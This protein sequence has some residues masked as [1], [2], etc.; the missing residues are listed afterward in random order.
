MRTRTRLGGAAAVTALAMLTSLALGSPASAA[1]TGESGP[2]QATQGLNGKACVAAA[3]S[4]TDRAVAARLVRI[5]HLQRALDAAPRVSAD[6]RAALEASYAADRKGLR[7]VRAEVRSD[8][9]CAEAKKDARRVVTSFRVYVLLT[10]QTSL[11]VRGDAGAARADADEALEPGYLEAIAALPEGDTKT[12]A[13]GA[14]V[15]LS[16]SVDAAQGAFRPVGDTVLALVPADYPDQAEVLAD[17]RDDVRTGR[18]AL[19]DAATA[20]AALDALLA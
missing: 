3:R 20:R 15:E 1:T 11:T 5:N 10:P 19:A 6:H 14:L 16:A 17:A 18:L 9:T 2:D 13:S 12:A 8:S 7:A 4:W